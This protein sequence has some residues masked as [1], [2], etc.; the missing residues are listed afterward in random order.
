MAA[1]VI[2]VSLLWCCQICRG[3][4]H[5][6]RL[7]A[8]CAG[9]DELRNY[10]LLFLV[11]YIFLLRMPSEALQIQAWSGACCLT[12]EGD[13]VILSLEKRKNRPGGSRLT[14]G[15]WCK[16]SRSTCPLHVLGPVLGRSARGDRL[17]PGISAASAL[18]VLRFVSCL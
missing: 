12:V 9:K 16:Q 14:R 13:S 17:F 5:V 18:S 8:Y 2:G 10:G 7:L 1:K 3:R 15:C 6:E 4:S 11:T